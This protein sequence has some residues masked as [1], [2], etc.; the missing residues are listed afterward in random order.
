MHFVSTCSILVST[1]LPCVER[2]PKPSVKGGFSRLRTCRIPFGPQLS[3]SRLLWRLIRSDQLKVLETVMLASPLGKHDQI[4]F[5][6]PKQVADFTPDG[7]SSTNQSHCRIRVHNDRSDPTDA[8]TS[9]KVW[10]SI[11]FIV[12]FRN[13]VPESGMLPVIDRISATPYPFAVVPGL[14]RQQV[15]FESFI[16]RLHVP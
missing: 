4:L 5:P 16:D 12:P 8:F 13:T 2:V 7:R 15:V 3:L 14:V 11:R 9:T 1:H 6:K 10:S